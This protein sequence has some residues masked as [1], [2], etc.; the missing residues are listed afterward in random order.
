[1]RRITVR[2]ADYVEEEKRRDRRGARA[3]VIAAL[4]AAIVIAMSRSSAPPPPA[5]PGTPAHLTASAIAMA[6]APQLAGTASD[7]QLLRL[8]NDGGAPL[9]ISKIAAD[10]DAFHVKNDCATLAPNESCSVAVVF[11][12]SAAGA[13]PALLGVQ[14]DSGTTTIALDGEGRAIPAVDLGATD[15]GQTAVGANT[16]RSI[17]FMN[18]GPTPIAVA[19][20][21]AG[22]PFAIA[23]DTCSGTV[24]PGVNCEVRVQFR[25]TAGGSATGELLLGGADGAVIAKGALLGA[26]SEAPPPPALKPA[27]LVVS[28][29]KLVFPPSPQL[30]SV[31]NDGDEALTIESISADERAVRLSGNC[32]KSL[33]GNTSCSL[34]VVFVGRGTSS[35]IVNTN[36]GRAVI[37]LEA[38]VRQPQ[39]VVLPLTDFGHAFLGN[40]VE[41]GV[42]FTNSAPATIAV[43]HATS[44]PPFAITLDACRGAKL[45]P[46]GTC[47]VRLQFRPAVDGIANGRLT[48]V[49]IGNNSVARGE[50]RG[51]GLS[52]QQLPSIEINPREINF[53]GDPGTKKVVITNTGAIPVTLGV[54]PETASRYLIDTSQCN[55]QLMPR[56]SC[57][58]SID[59]RIAVRIGA[60]SRIVVSYAG[61]TEIV[62]VDAG[63]KP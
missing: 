37:Q 3:V 27:H 42:R 6:F 12:P 14:T 17:H 23:A 48:L 53:H 60:S 52:Q 57:T 43:G 39:P 32:G 18:S 34:S 50:L 33:A 15:F 29:Q 46:G 2:L 44:T 26:G 21:S 40:A 55:R 38:E 51:I 62:S 49:D 36:G 58:I 25:P 28:P 10:K 63:G 5:N 24:A 59:G 8:R 41:R 13:Q 30:V 16:E 20:T 45:A 1:M 11:A 35:I 7:A 19:K 54:K 61:R 22:V 56:D 47:E 4:V 9:T 31:K